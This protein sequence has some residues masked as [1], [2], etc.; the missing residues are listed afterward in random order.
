MVSASLSAAQSLF[1]CTPSVLLTW[2]G[3]HGGRNALPASFLNAG[4]WHCFV[5]GAGAR[6]RMANAEG[7]AVQAKGS[8]NEH[9]EHGVELRSSRA[10]NYPR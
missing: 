7:G 8:A 3:R 4:K 1:S 10:L 5:S 9:G 6:V 2:C